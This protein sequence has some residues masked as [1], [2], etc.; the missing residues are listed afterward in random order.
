MTKQAWEKVLKRSLKETQRLEEAGL[1]K[2]GIPV[3][4]MGD[5]IGDIDDDEVDIS[6]RP[7]LQPVAAN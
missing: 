2:D 5:E 4:P 7:K 6:E 3:K 1:V